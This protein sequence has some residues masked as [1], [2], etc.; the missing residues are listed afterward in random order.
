MRA[1]AVDTV[2]ATGR[3]L[4]AVGALIAPPTIVITHTRGAVGVLAARVA[5]GA[6]RTTRG[7]DRA[8]ER[9]GPRVAVEP[10]RVVFDA[11]VERFESVLQFVE[12]VVAESEPD[13]LCE[14]GKGRGDG[15]CEEVGADVHDLQ[16]GQAPDRG[17]E[18][19]T[20]VVAR[21]VE[22]SQL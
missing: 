10:A 5:L 6:L 8:G 3:A 9:A 15:A 20:E 2:G 11:V 12:L 19:P 4:Q 18:N 14:T 22:K 16:F 17:G 21:Q 13:N 7:W 1:A